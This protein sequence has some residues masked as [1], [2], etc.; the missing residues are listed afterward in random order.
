M[1]PPEEASEIVKRSG[2]ARAGCGFNELIGE[3]GSPF[4]DPPDEGRLRQSDAVSPTRGL[5]PIQFFGEAQN[6][7]F[8]DLSPVRR[9]TGPPLRRVFVFLGLHSPKSGANHRAPSA[10]VGFLLIRV[11]APGGKV[12]K[13]RSPAPL[14]RQADLLQ[15]E[16]LSR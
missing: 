6:C 5:A 4:R 3:H 13:L 10:M 1:G 16:K 15:L 2:R 7:Q 8:A 12:T 9:D 14:A 11:N